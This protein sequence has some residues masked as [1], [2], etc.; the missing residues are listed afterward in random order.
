M[1]I[2]TSANDYWK[3][4]NNKE[5]DQEIRECQRLAET[6]L[7]AL[8]DLNSQLAWG[9]RFISLD[10]GDSEIMNMISEDLSNAGFNFEIVGHKKIEILAGKATNT[11][12]T[13]LL[14][15]KRK[16]SWLFSF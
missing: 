5:L 2:T 16:F 14:K 1:Q 11:K 10:R 15:K 8:A 3:V 12:E 13:E 6:Y 9:L 7:H 4:R